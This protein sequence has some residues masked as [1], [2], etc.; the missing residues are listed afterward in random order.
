MPAIAEGENQSKDIA[1]TAVTL[2][3]VF[4]SI[5]I[6]F[7]IKSAPLWRSWLLAQCNSTREEIPSQRSQVINL[8]IEA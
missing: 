6:F 1:A 2:I 7:F 5:L 4:F 3:L 8:H